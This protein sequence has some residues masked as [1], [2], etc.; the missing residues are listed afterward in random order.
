MLVLD[1]DHL[2]L[3]QQLSAS[4]EG[5]RLIHRLDQHP[6]EVIVTTIITYEEH[7]RGWLAYVAK[8]RSR[9]QQVNAYRK[10]AIHANAY[11]KHKLLEFDDRAASRFE[12]LQKTKLGVG[13]Q[14]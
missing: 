1:T 14:D 13:T 8:A 2:T 4:D 10:L 3:L 12:Q 9:I 6:Q 5:L 7:C 11:A